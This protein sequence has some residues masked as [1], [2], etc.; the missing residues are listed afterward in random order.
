MPD[1]SVIA[2]KTFNNCVDRK[3]NGIYLRDTKPLDGYQMKYLYFFDKGLEK[4]FK[5]VDFDKIPND[6]K[7]YR[8]IKRSKHKINASDFQSEEGGATPT[9]TLQTNGEEK[10]H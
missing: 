7:M 2:D 5:F 8:G 1:G 6:V 4:R 9:A 3:I 10:C